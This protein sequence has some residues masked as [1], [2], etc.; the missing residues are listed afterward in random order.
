VLSSDGSHARYTYLLDAP[1]GLD[2]RQHGDHVLPALLAAIGRYAGP[3]WRPSWIEV[4]SLRD[5]EV[6]LLADMVSC[7]V[8]PRAKALVIAFPAALLGAR[9]AASDHAAALAWRSLRQFARTAPPQ[10]V[11]DTVREIAFARLFDRR[12][13]L[14]G[15]AGK[16]N[17]GVRTLQRRLEREGVGYRAII[18]RVR[19]RHAL[20]LLTDSDLPITEIAWS[21]GYDDPAHF[22]RAFRR[23][24]GMPPT[25]YRRRARAQLDLDQPAPGPLG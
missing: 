17:I 22:S 5:R 2:Y 24:A 19:H 23:T 6:E 21:L 15:V 16:L 1:S 8:R 7:E 25:R 13:D 10:T 9:A 12:V 11:S 20:D 3:T 14:D 4:K 18:Q